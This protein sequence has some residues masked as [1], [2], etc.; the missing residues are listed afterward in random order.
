GESL[1]ASG[2]AQRYLAHAADLT[3]DPRERAALL[4]R[5]GWLAYHAADLDG[6]V[7]LLGESVALYEGQ[8]ETHAAAR[9]SGRLSLV[10]RW[11]GHFDEALERME[12]AYDVLADDEPDEDIAQLLS[13]LGGAYVFTG[14][15][16]RAK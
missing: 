13:R 6:A 12:R 10:E 9:V 7:Q 14:D 11:Q 15:V 3:D 2:E 4:D 8:S 16:D 5:A 1:A